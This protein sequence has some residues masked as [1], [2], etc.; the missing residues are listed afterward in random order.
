MIGTTI[1][2]EAGH[3]QLGDDSKCGKL[4][5][6][7]WKVE[8]KID[9]EVDKI[10]YIIDFKE[11]KD[12]LEPFDHAMILNKNDEFVKILQERNQKVYVMD[13]NPSCENLS[14]LICYLITDLFD[15][16]SYCYVKLWENHNSY[17]EYKMSLRLP[18]IKMRGMRI[19]D[20][21]GL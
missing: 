19:E 13:E 21:R 10:G 11:L 5:G 6:H 2:F 16:V 3:R 9:G 7:N 20:A 18:R 4:H 15:N 12:L 8:I 17:G 14:E 1:C